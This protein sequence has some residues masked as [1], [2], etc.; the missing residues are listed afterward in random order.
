MQHALIIGGGIAGPALAMFFSQIGI[1]ATVYEA[2]PALSNIG[3]G[4]QLAPNGMHV[5]AALGLARRVKDAGVIATHMRFQNH[6][7]RH[8]ATVSNGSEERY[9]QPSVVLARATLHR[10]I[11]DEALRQ[12]VRIEYGKRLKQLHDVDGAPLVAEFEDGTTASGDFLVGADGIWSQTR[13]LIIPQ[14]PEP[15]HTGL[16]SFGGFASL[17]GADAVDPHTMYMTLG[18]NGFFGYSHTLTEA[19]IRPMW[20]STR[21]QAPGTEMAGDHARE[22]LLAAHRG[23]PKPIEAL[24]SNTE[25]ILKGAIYDVPT[26]PAW[27]RGRAVLI[28]DAAHAISPHAGQGASIALEDAVVLASLLRENQG[29][30]PATFARFEAARR[31]RVEKIVAQ[32]RRNGEHKRTLT[33]TAAWIRDRFISALA[34]RMMKRLADETYAYKVNWPGIEER[35]A[36]ESPANV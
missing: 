34:P 10:I 7:G 9:G 32:A 12:G 21:P 18:L 26:L 14:A 27:T 1:R 11:V 22:E 36:V 29:G 15:V 6:L 23:W 17:S 35:A 13:K 8:L 5:V 33:P 20:W 30:Y 24:I 2:Y 4:L 31:P 25:H 16:A 3:A 19:G 28:G